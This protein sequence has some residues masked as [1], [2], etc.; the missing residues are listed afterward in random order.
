MYAMSKI[1]QA[2]FL[3]LSKSLAT[4]M[5]TQDQI[6]LKGLGSTS[7]VMPANPQDSGNKTGTGEANNATKQQNAEDQKMDLLYKQVS[8]FIQTHHLQGNVTLSEQARGVQITLR[9]MVLFDTG[10]ATIKPNAQK[11]LAGLVPFFRSLDNPIVVE[12]YTD[13]QPISTPQYPTNWELSAA[14]ATGVVRFFVTQHIDPSRLTAS[15]YGEYHPVAPNDT[16]AHRQ[17][18]RRVN[19]VILRDD[20]TAAQN[21]PES[22]AQVQNTPQ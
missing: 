4:A 9:D 11:L 10:Q 15:G 16:E 22:T 20:L 13:N 2:K 8:Q 17:L 18:N 1:D 7:L 5:H 14:R 12:G 6:P 21:T 19:I 3:T